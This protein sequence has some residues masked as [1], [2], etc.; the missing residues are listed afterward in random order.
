[1][2]NFD[3]T[4]DNDKI[5]SEEKKNVVDEASKD[6]TVIPERYDIASYGADF[7]V[8]GVVKRLRNG[9]IF[10][11]PFQRDYVWNLNEASRFI[12]SLLLGLPVPGVFLAKETQSNKMLVIDGQQRL[13]TLQFFY[14]GF[15]NP[16]PLDKTKKIFKLNGVQKPFD[17]KSYVE[18]FDNDRLKLNDSIIHATI[19][20]Q[21]SPEDNDTSV[22][23]VFERLNSGGRR[24]QPQEI[25]KAIYHG[26][27]ND[28]IA[29]LNKHENWRTIYGPIS[30][31]MKDEE[32]ILRFF[33]LL[34]NRRN[35]EKPMYEFLN[36]FNAKHRNDKVNNMNQFV[37]DF[38]DTIDAVFTAIGEKAFRPERSINV[39]VLDSVLVGIAERL[40]RG[41]IT[42]YQSVKIAYSKL[43]I[44]EQY[45]KATTQGTS[46][47]Q[48][49]NDRI[50]YALTAFINVP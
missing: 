26:N 11:P 39:A 48:T 38:S 13:K 3:S 24:L 16:K 36:K 50:S 49:V 19:I 25:R 46:D 6:D 23:H 14:D 34:Y 27:F 9:D 10:V 40:K 31:R 33:A 42:N 29:S 20:K 7:D 22:Y 35:Y 12:E 45:K 21:E 1:M 43:L 28:L 2:S 32:L 18:L 8:D 30:K 4:D 5:D 44:D 47:E 17:D 41:P 15:F 37:K